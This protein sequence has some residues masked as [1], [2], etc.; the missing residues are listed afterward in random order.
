[1]TSPRQPAVRRFPPPG[2]PA[3]F[4]LLLSFGA[5]LVFL[6]V[7]RHAAYVDF[8]RQVTTFKDGGGPSASVRREFSAEPGPENNVWAVEVTFSQPQGSRRVFEAFL[9]GVPVGSRSPARRT[10]LLEF[11]GSMLAPGPNVLE[12]R[13][14]APWTFRRLRV[15]NIYGYS[16]GFPAAV[17]FHRDNS[18]PEARRLPL[19]S[20]SGL[21]AILAIV[22]AAAASAAAAL[23]GPAGR[24][25]LSA[26]ERARYLITGLLLASLFL[27]AISRFRVWFEWRSMLV[28]VLAFCAL[29]LVHELA[30]LIKGLLDWIA[31]LGAAAGSLLR[32]SRA[33]FLQRSG[34][35][36]ILAWLLIA[37]LAFICLIKPGP[38]VRSGDSLEYVAM[39]VSWAE[40]GRPYVTAD[41]IKI[42]EKRLGQAPEPG[43][44]AFFRSLRER[45]PALLKN[46][47]EMD[48]PHFWLYSLGASV[49]YHPVRLLSLNIGLAFMLLHLLIVVAG[50][51]VIRKALGR[52]AGLCFLL[53]I[54]FSPLI[55][56]VNKV[57][58]ELFTVV[59]VCSGAALLAAE[60]WAGSAL[61]FALAATQNPPFAILAGLVFLLGFVRQKW[62]VFRGRW[63]L[64]AAA[65]GL[66]AAQP[67]YYLL[68]LGILNPVVAT[69]AARM[70]TDVFSLRRMFSFI[71][72]PDIG[73]FANWP[74]ALLILLLFA[75]QA[76]RGKAGFRS[77]TWVFL[78]VSLPVLLWS[79]SR[80]LNLNH[81]GTR[82]ISRYALWYLYV[83]FVILWQLGRSLQASDRRAKRAWF[84]AGVLAAAFALV[85]F[86]PSRPEEYLRPTPVSQ[87]LYSRF[88]G[89]YD[90]MPEIFTERYRRIEE[91]LPE[92]VWAVSNPTGSKILIRWGRMQ[93]VR[94]W[95]K[96]D[97]IPTCP[98][99]DPD[100][101]Y[102]EAQRR[103]EAAPEKKYL[104]INGL[105]GKLRRAPGS[106]AAPIQPH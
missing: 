97:P 43:E 91:H 35:A 29:A 8:P 12:V 95:P 32:Q 64:L 3:V 39:L 98:A 99:L 9:N 103:F 93:V 72:D 26:L 83:F 53:L 73:L 82:F 101:V 18:Y 81:G 36:G 34:S 22:L 41:S 16:S 56:F 57:H 102:T 69:G 68:R 71:V 5:A 70:D 40:F 1:M 63:P 33:R 30:A 84:A 65:F 87:W 104:Y 51:L 49:F 38:V 21:M 6:L 10:L 7:F 47:T 78:A 42:M 24:G 100:L 44:S 60:N 76:A 79:Q 45:F 48:L 11:P 37:I 75:V 23:K 67:V 62:A 61:S 77:P 2:R 80:S 55:W 15:K 85:E 90:P 17:L 25:R 88:P 14:D 66:A 96:L 31:S 54:V 4:K 20:P 86:W 19:G 106:G 105:A 28:L 50:F 52:A 58:V 27:P 94:Y 13:S 92:D 59:L 89:V 46:G 74:V